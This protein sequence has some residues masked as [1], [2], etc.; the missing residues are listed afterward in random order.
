MTLVSAA[1]IRRRA[2]GRAR[3]IDPQ[4][5]WQME[6]RWK[7][8][9]REM[10]R[11]GSRATPRRLRAYSPRRAGQLGISQ[12]SLVARAALAPKGRAGLGRRRDHMLRAH[13]SSSLSSWPVRWACASIFVLGLGLSACGGKTGGT[14]PIAGSGSSPAPTSGSVGSTVAGS[15]ADSDVSGGSPIGGP[16]ATDAECSAGLACAFE[17]A[18]GCSSSIGMCQSVL[19]GSLCAMEPACTC[20]GTTD[21][22]P[23]CGLGGA[24][25]QYAHEPI[26]HVGPCADGGPLAEAGAVEATTVDGTVPD[27]GP[28]GAACS[29][30]A[31]DYDQ[32]CTSDSDCVEV[33][34]GDICGPPLCSCPNAAINVSAQSAYSADLAKLLP[35]GP[36]A[37][38]CGAADLGPHCN[39][40][41]CGRCLTA[42]CNG[43]CVDE[44]TDPNNC[45]GCG[46]ACAVGLVCHIGTCGNPPSCAPGG[47]GMTNCGPGGSGTE[48]CCASLGVTGGTFYRT[49]D[50]SF[51]VPL[52]ADGG[53]TA[54]ADPA[55]VSSVR[56]DKYSVTVGRF[57]QFVSAVSPPDG[58]AGWL[59]APGSGKH[60]YLSGG[61][62]LANSA[63]PPGYEPGWS[64]LDNVNIAPTDANLSCGTWTP[65]P[66]V[67]ENFPINCVNWYEAYA[68][69]I[70]DGGFLPSEAEWEYAAAG[71]INRSWHDES[72]RH[73]W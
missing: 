18:A 52:T 59:P 34:E 57:R 30:Q 65:S 39:S 24:N 43:A 71:G 63:A 33:V 45:G 23:G 47:A 6:I 51:F 17:V 67:Q 38:N 4:N 2:L 31:S 36:V 5:L 46:K 8:D 22:T 14:T 12:P 10:A 11:G 26:A 62:G 44:Q 70:W 64:A 25:G 3:D 40:G 60:A 42:S 35:V 48:S 66:G 73:L 13:V 1:R 41:V 9:E 58:G 27:G 37:C 28:E 68:F 61:N 7:A 21:P 49:Y 32:S 16:C 50:T 19:M 72:I 69:C 53:P 55:T 54:E 15:G 20:V 29:I 56:L